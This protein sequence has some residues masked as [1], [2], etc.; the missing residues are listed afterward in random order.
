MELYSFRLFQ[1]KGLG[2]CLKR[3]T[4]QDAITRVVPVVVKLST[5]VEAAVRQTVAE[6]FGL[7]TDFL[8]DQ[9]ATSFIHPLICDAHN[10]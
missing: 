10:P 4:G 2:E 7:L 1:V 8:F 6:E 9:V 5:D 3:V